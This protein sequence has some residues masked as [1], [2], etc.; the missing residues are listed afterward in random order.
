MVGR[1]GG[2]GGYPYHF[3]TNQQ[4][5]TERGRVSEDKK[6][7]SSGLP[8]KHHDGKQVYVL[9]SFVSREREVRVRVSVRVRVRV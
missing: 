7:N 6:T 8:K 2:E 4:P 3:L 9:L 5:E 1:G